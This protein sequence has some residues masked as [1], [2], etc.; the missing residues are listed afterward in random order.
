MSPEQ[1]KI[2]DADVRE[3]V[4]A[5]GQS[6]IVQAPAGSGKTTLLASRYVALLTQ[7]ARPEEILAITFTKKAAAEMRHR[8]LKML[9][10]DTPLAAAVLARD[11]E[12]GWQ[13]FTNPNVLK[14]QTIDS[15]ALDVASQVPSLSQASGLGIVERAQL[16][17]A[18]AAHRLFNRL[19]SEDQT[20]P[21]VAQFLGFLDNDINRAIRLLSFMLA[22]RDQWLE[23]VRAVATARGQAQTA[24]LVAQAIQNIRQALSD[25]LEAEFTPAD[26]AML[27]QLA[28]VWGLEDVRDAL[29]PRLLTAKD[30]LR[31]RLTVKEDI[32][33]ASL[34]KSTK[35]WL[36]ELDLRGLGPLI[37][38]YTKLPKAFDPEAI[39]PA[40][41]AMLT[42]LHLC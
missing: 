31:K 12:L 27:Q 28:D 10:E 37:V 11:R 13:I 19:Y 4:L 42:N 15:F 32:T 16:N 39:S 40:E 38:A 21:L 20:N 36:E 14:I 24:Q 22:R 23:P 3:H 33:D 41:Q 26:E 8:V 1:K 34:K 30:E 7:V 29:L 18:S 9:A 6:F 5:P 17:Y 2:P 25:Q 35:I